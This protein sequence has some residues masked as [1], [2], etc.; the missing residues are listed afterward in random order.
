MFKRKFAACILP[1]LLITIA[2]ACS[3]KEDLKD[4]DPP[5]QVT[6]KPEDTTTTPSTFTDNYTSG[7]I[8]YGSKN[9][10]Q[11]V[12]GDSA[13][14][15]IIT[16]PHG[17]TLRPAYIPDRTQG[18][19]NADLNTANLAYRIADS[20]KARTGI[21]PHIVL[22]NL[23]RIKMEPNRAVGDAYLTHDSAIVAHNEYHDFIIIAKR[24]VTE[25]VGK[26]LLL[27]I[28]GHGH[29]IDR[30]EVGYTTS[31]AVINGTDANLNNYG[32]TS[33]IKYI[34]TNS[35]STYSSLVRGELAFGSL[36]AKEGLPAVPSDVDPSPGA[37]PYFNGGY[38][39]ARHGSRDSG[40]ISAIQLEFPRPSV[41]ETAT[42]RANAASKL[43]P[44]IRMY[45]KEHLGIDL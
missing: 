26:G 31:K 43:V 2:A 6:P 20:I 22:N 21:K 5:D 12:V 16:A 13:T 19:T 38:T 3:K 37:D 36:M 25:R 33:S 23:H 29:A 4:E 44:V 7:Q 35:D 28:H 17:G 11:L 1:V 9:Y 32:S 30:T 24:M 42:T 27:D 40:T 34:W 41:R 15:L 14:P 10:V 8:V 45:I 18:E 39:T